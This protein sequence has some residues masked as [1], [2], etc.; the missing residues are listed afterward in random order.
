[1]AGRGRTAKPH[2]PVKGWCVSHRA[3]C[4]TRG[5]DEPCRADGASA[6]RGSAGAYAI[7][8]VLMK[9]RLSHFL[10]A[11]TMQLMPF[12]VVLTTVQVSF[13]VEA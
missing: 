8:S 5:K 11:A 7:G 4:A 1:M 10:P 13:C 9:G 3:G 2:R 6:D 12:G